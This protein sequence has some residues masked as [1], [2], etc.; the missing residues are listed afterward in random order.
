MCTNSP[1]SFCW[2]WDGQLLHTTP[3]LPA[4]ATTSACTPL[5][6]YPPKPQ[7]ARPHTQS[8]SGCTCL[9]HLSSM[10]HMRDTK[11]ARVLACTRAYTAF[12]RPRPHLP[13]LLPRPLPCTPFLVLMPVAR[14]AGVRCT[15]RSA[16]QKG[17]ADRPASINCKHA[18][19]GPAPHPPPLLRSPL[20]QERQH[21]QTRHQ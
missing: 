8:S 4:P 12:P 21:K 16:L 5:V 3:W 17:G 15:E 1:L 9:R 13:A 11:F 19:R 6:I 14:N 18:R 2:L 7:G 20:S 10:L